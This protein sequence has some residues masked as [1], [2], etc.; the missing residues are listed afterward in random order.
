MQWE[1]IPIYFPL[2]EMLH[3]RVQI[4]PLEGLFLSANLSE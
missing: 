1:K 2:V 3:L 4:D